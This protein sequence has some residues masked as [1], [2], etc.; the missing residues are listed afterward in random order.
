[1]AWNPSDKGASI[2]LS[3]SDQDAAGGSGL[4]RGTQGRITNTTATKHYFEILI[5][6]NSGDESRIGIAQLSSASGPTTSQT[7]GESN[8]SYAWRD[9]SGQLRYFG[10]NVLSLSSFVTNDVLGFAL[11]G[12]AS[13]SASRTLKLYKNGTLVNTLTG[14]GNSTWYPVVSPEHSSAKVTLRESATALQYL[15]S[16]YT[17][18]DG[19]VAVTPKKV[20]CVNW[21]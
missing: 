15:P 11:D 16:G 12:H 6:N 17:A 3:N 10:N 18:W 5:V 2:T 8:E 14:I 19:S 21:F 7:A 9:S 1:M 4:V 20:R 13:T